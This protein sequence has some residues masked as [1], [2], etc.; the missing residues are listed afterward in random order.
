MEMKGLF[1]LIG[2]ALIMGAIATFLYYLGLIN[3]MIAFGV[4]LGSIIFLILT[5]KK[6][7]KNLK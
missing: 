5:C 7:C 2:L 3:I 4:L 6:E 1:A